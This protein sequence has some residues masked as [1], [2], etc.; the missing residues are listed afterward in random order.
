MYSFYVDVYII[1]SKAITLIAYNSSVNKQ[2]SR[3]LYENK[4]KHLLI[5]I[6]NDDPSVDSYNRAF[7]YS[8]LLYNKNENPLLNHLHSGWNVNVWTLNNACQKGRSNTI[9]ATKHSNNKLY[10][11]LVK[12]LAREEYLHSRFLGTLTVSFPLKAVMLSIS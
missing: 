8:K 10:S 12:Y 6:S 5:L 7:V 1:S 4:N 2:I 9:W 11:R 3:F